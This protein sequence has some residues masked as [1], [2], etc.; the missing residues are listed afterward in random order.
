MLNV[1]I[2]GWQAADLQGLC[3]AF[4]GS[5]V[6]AESNVSDAIKLATLILIGAAVRSA[7]VSRSFGTIR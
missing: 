6:I 2:F 7:A 5:S 3:Q 1:V 4:L